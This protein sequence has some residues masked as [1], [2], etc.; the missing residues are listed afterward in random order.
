MDTLILRAKM[1]RKWRKWIPKVVETIKQLLPDAEI[2]IIGSIAREEAIAASDL[3]LLVISQKIPEKPL[4]RAKLVATIEE[5]AKLPLYHPVEFH[6]IKPKDK[7]AYLKR[8]PEH[9]K[10]S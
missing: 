5:R 2:Y 9:I 3:D 7:Q 4:E 8:N 10:L 1:L 6:L